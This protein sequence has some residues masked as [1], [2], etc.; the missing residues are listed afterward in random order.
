VKFCSNCLC[1]S[2]HSTFF[3]H[4]KKVHSFRFN[5]GKKIKLSNC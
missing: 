5:L 3:I 2:I 4:L 1:T